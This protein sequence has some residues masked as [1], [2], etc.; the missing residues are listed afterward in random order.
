MQIIINVTF[1]A[2]FYKEVTILGAFSFWAI[3]QEFFLKNGTLHGTLGSLIFQLKSPSCGLNLIK[4]R[5][6][7]IFYLQSSAAMR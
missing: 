7:S 2:K 4:F 1:W 6:L 3:F 5:I